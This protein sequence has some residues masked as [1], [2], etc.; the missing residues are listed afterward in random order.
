MKKTF[1]SANQGSALLIVLGLLSFLMI[2]AVAFSISMRTER[3]AAASYRRGLLGR[4]LL[5]NTF[6]DARATLENAL[7]SQQRGFN[8]DDPATRTLEN[9]APFKAPNGNKYGRVMSSV[10]ANQNDAIAYLLDDAV[11]AHVPPYVASPVYRYLE[12]GIRQDQEDVTSDSPYRLDGPAGWKQITLK[13]PEINGDNSDVTSIVVGRM[14]W[15]IV[16][17]SDSLDIN[18]IGSASTR[19][20]LGLTA[21][22]FAF[23]DKSNQPS[24]GDPTFQLLSS[25]K[26]SKGEPVDLPIFCSNG[27]IARYAAKDGEGLV[28]E[29]AGNIYPYA[30]QSAVAEDGEGYY[31]PFS[32][33]SFWPNAERKDEKG[34]RRV[35]TGAS[36]T[37]TIL[38]NEVKESELGQGDSELSQRILDAA[39]DCIRSGGDNAS[40]TQM[41]LRSLVDYV[42][43]DDEPVEFVGHV[44]ARPTVENVP[45]VAEVAYDASAYWSDGGDLK[46]DLVDQVKKAVDDVDT[47]SGKLDNLNNFQ[48]TLEGETF[49][50]EL[51]EAEIELALRAYCP[52]YE[53]LKDSYDV[54][55]EGF[56]GAIAQAWAEGEGGT[57]TVLKCDK[58]GQ[59]TE[60][61]TRGSS[62]T[63]DD[64]ADVFTGVD[65][66]RCTPA[67]TLKFKFEGDN[68]PVT[69]EVPEASEVV[70]VSPPAPQKVTITCLM[71][72]IFRVNVTS[73][74]TVVDRSPTDRERGEEM[75]KGDYPTKLSARLTEN[76]MKELD[77]Q[78]FRVTC[79]L[80]ITFALAWELSE[81]R[82]TQ[83]NKMEYR[84]ERLKIVGEEGEPEIKVNFDEELKFHPDRDN[85]KLLASTEVAEKSFKVLPPNQ[86]VWRT[87]DPR[88]NWLSPMLGVR[89]GS[90]ASRYGVN[91]FQ[92]NLS[93]PHWIFKANDT[94]TD[95]DKASDEQQKYMAANASY[96]PFSW[97]LSVEEIRYGY[98]N[99]GQLILP[100]EVGFLPVP[101]SADE[102]HPN[103]YKYCSN[104]IDDY[105]DEVA[106]VSFFRTI[107]LVDFNDGAT[108]YSRYTGLNLLFKSFSGESFP[109]EHRGVVHAFAAQDNY[110]LAQQLRQFA[111][112][113]I[114]NTMTEA[115]KNTND[116]LETASEQKKVPQQMI[117]D[118]QSSLK[119]EDVGTTT[120]E[121]KY[122]QFVVKH[123]FPLPDEDAEWPEGER[124]Q[125]IDF[126]LQGS[127]AL[128]DDGGSSSSGSFIDKLTEYNEAGSGEKLGQND[129]TMLLSVARESF[130]DRQQL[131]LFILRADAIAYSYG[132]DLANFR[133]QSTARAVALVWRDAYG[134]LPD[135]VV[136][137]QVLP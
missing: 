49:E 85:E 136:Y 78:Y 124:P 45:M 60:L 129:M 25:S 134:E 70:P 93:S 88:Y 33:Y 137:Y 114:P 128:E 99:S 121:S 20:G 75:K 113:G 15:A 90:S 123:L 22:E 1:T 27:D 2:S 111:L 132:R 29:G 54:E 21:N 95:G 116:R 115:I 117:T 4:E 5:E 101:L 69:F 14:A 53:T 50:I 91:D 107:P 105:Y 109:E 64:G 32:C 80:Q 30:W 120:T 112:L 77:A 59:T 43:K 6:A 19:R 74:S 55:I 37:A 73:G 3:A 18:A 38:C 89:A 16:N 10:R 44:H 84:Y 130:G 41:F 68:I 131:F 86:G 126:I 28:T 67:D 110:Y 127:G 96:V 34:T 102:L 65:G 62:L 103:Q 108:T 31:S 133:P 71:D 63:V 104:N 8:P 83:S 56:V 42:D 72:Y 92:S 82:N 122:D 119:V 17:L 100:G 52:G 87:I 76:E 94:I 35:T 23:F 12:E 79:P 11:M 39:N 106:K 135:R 57:A 47:P 118:L 24:G 66:I 7:R 13:T 40:A 58:A 98:N 26:D 36:N 125:T 61:K 48:K 9:L 97:N 81:N 51:P 46:D